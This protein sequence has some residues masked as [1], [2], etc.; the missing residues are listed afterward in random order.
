MTISINSSSGHTRLCLCQLSLGFTVDFERKFMIKSV[1][2]HYS[3][4]QFL[5]F[6]PVL[7]NSFRVNMKISHLRLCPCQLSL[8]FIVEFGRKLKA[9]SDKMHYNIDHFLIFIQPL[10]NFLQS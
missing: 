10:L 3:T 9:K 5:L 8:G 1:T 6:P 2:M 4:D 7:L